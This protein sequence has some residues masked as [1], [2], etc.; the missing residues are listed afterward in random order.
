MIYMFAT[1][2][3]AFPLIISNAFSLRGH[4]NLCCYAVI[5]SECKHKNVPSM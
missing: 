5:Y 2:V 4:S 3:L 1:E